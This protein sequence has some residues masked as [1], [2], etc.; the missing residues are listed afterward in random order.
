V[1]NTRSNRNRRKVVV[2]SLE[3]LYIGIG[4]SALALKQTQKAIKKDTMTLRVNVLHLLGTLRDL[5]AMKRSLLLALKAA[6]VQA[7]TP[8]S[9]RS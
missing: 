7:K 8:K 6:G 1:K 4:L 2:E 5:G 3:R 9:P